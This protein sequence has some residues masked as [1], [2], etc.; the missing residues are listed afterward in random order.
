MLFFAFGETDGE[1]DTPPGVVQIERD[2]RVASS[3]DLAD[4]FGN[5]LTMHEQFACTRR[6]GLDVRRSGGEGTDMGADQKQL[7]SLDHDICLFQL[8]AA[9]T[10]CLDFP[11]FEGKTGLKP[12]F[13][14]VV[15]ERL[16][17]LYDAHGVMNATN[18]VIL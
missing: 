10:Y 3:F 17:V 13:D 11:A 5:F 12:F 18:F 4:Q 9:G 7:G 1:F 8:R 16:F 14:E 15:V 6:V 2:K